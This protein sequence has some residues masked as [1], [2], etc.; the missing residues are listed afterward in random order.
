MIMLINPQYTEPAPVGG[1]SDPPLYEPQFYITQTW[2]RC[3]RR[4]QLQEE[5]KNWTTPFP[6][7]FLFCFVSSQTTRGQH[8]L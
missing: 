7:C 6:V 8:F 2:F 1:Q 4:K 5:F 3:T